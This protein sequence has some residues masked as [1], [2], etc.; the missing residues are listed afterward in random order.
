MQLAALF[1]QMLDKMWDM[2]NKMDVGRAKVKADRKAMGK[3]VNA[4]QAL[5]KAGQAGLG[6]RSDVFL[7]EHRRSTGDVA[8]V[9]DVQR[10]MVTGEDRGNIGRTP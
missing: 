9:R 4:G 5:A 1:S 7:G 10:V 8:C 3:E 2:N 6:G